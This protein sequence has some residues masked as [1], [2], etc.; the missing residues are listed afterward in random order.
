M[1]P[2]WKFVSLLF[3]TWLLANPIFA[4]DNVLTGLWYSSGTV[5]SEGTTNNYMGE[6]N[7]KQSGK[8]VK[9]TFDYYF[10][11]SLFTMEVEG[12][13]DHDTRYLVL[14][15]FPIML[16]SSYSTKIGVEC[17]MRGE[18]IVRFSRLGMYMGGKFVADEKYR[19]TC[20]DISFDFSKST[21][22]VSIFA[23]AKKAQEA[24]K[25]DTLFNDE[26][27][28]YT[29]KAFVNRP[30]DYFKE[31]WVQSREIT[32]EIVDNGAI[33]YDSVSLFV[34]NKIVVKKTML[35]RLP[36]KLV[37]QLNDSLPFN[38]VSMFANNV[39]LIPPNTAT[40]TLTDGDN[41][42]ELE[43]NSDLNRTATLKLYRRRF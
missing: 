39:G 13:F 12:N 1:N 14:K 43:L 24:A 21:D 31:I 5:N 28:Q 38:E 16:H 15:P 9:G 3:F 20:P 8:Q 2:S 35:S 36:I 37:L 11:D 32:L 30:K 18:F 6:L 34:N 17:S 26:T 29:V 10:R 27:S 40:L 22:N 4:Q 41:K 23:E 33:D 42:T 25:A 7:L 19:Y